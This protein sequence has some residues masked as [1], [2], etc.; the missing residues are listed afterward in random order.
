MS[1]SKTKFVEV[2]KTPFLIDP[3][4]FVILEACDGHRIVADRNCVAVSRRLA[5]LIPP[6][7]APPPPPAEPTKKAGA[8]AGPGKGANEPPPPPPTN[9]GPSTVSPLFSADLGPGHPAALASACSPPVVSAA[10]QQQQQ[11]QAQAQA[12]SSNKKANA[13]AAA[14]SDEPPVPTA[15]VPVIK[16]ECLDGRQLEAALRICYLKYMGDNTPDAA[17]RRTI[18]LEQLAVSTDELMAIGTILGM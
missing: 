4:V 16:V 7:I 18:S 17:Q 1:K 12:Q 11:Q 14:A 2:T 6:L 15:I 8:G 13:A 9:R 10:N 5:D 3:T